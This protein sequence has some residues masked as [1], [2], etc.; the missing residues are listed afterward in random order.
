MVKE[1]NK[2]ATRNCNRNTSLKRSTLQPVGVEGERGLELGFMNIHSSPLF[3]RSNK[4]KYLVEAKTNGQ[5]K[6][7][8]NGEKL[9]QKYE[10]ETVNSTTDGGGR[11]EGA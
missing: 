5:R 9:Q 7:Q 3:T 8:T 11:R 6:K 1:S 2:P 10:L 4:T